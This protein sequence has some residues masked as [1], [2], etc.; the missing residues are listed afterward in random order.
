MHFQVTSFLRNHHW[1]PDDFISILLMVLQPSVDPLP[2]DAIIWQVAKLQATDEKPG[3]CYQDGVDHCAISNM[4]IG[5][6]LFW[7]WK[8]S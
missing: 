6:P 2:A 8:L 3:L 1:L 7:N 4:A 5:F